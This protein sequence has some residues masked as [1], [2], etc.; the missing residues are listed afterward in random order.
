[1]GISTVLEMMVHFLFKR[2]RPWDHFVWSWPTY[3]Q[4]LHDKRNKN[5]SGLE[6]GISMCVWFFFSYMDTSCLWGIWPPCTV[7]TYIP[8]EAT[9]H[10]KQEYIWGVGISM[11]FEIIGHFLFKGDGTTMYGYDLHTIRCYLK[12]RQEYVWF[13]GGDLNSFRNIWALPV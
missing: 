8:P 10:K 9:W 11:V 13:K 2:G 3:H 12:K 4:M 6:V 1:V 7:M 5:I